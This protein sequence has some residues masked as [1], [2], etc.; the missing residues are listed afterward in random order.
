M[1]KWLL[2]ITIAILGVAFF[3]LDLNQLLTL[4]GVQRH[5]AQFEQWRTDAP[6]LVGMIFLAIYV[7]VTALSLP[8]AAV[9]TL[10]A[11][12]LFGL[13]WGTLIVS[14][15]STIGATCAFLVARYL[16]KETVQRRFGERL[17]ALNHGVEKDGA[18]YL[19]TLRLVPIFPFFLINILMGLT[20]LRA[21][22]FYWVSQLGMLAGTL[23]Y[24]NAGT[25]LAQLDSLRGILSPAILFSFALLGIFPLVAK[26]VV[27]KINQ[28]RRVSE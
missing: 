14:F 21:V 19:F 16:L 18:F 9:M 6:L 27:E 12:A 4:D 5:L 10:A 28:R 11:G 3:A 24:V 23:V 8:G 15:A 22:T 13:W 25:Q 7:L 2:L 17:Q 20:T 26:K 1:K